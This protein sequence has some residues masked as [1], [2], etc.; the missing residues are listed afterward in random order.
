MEQALSL[1]LYDAAIP[2][3][4]RMLRNLSVMLDKAEAHATAQGLD[5]STL[6]DARLAPDM[7]PLTRQIQSVSDAAKG[8]AAR[9]AGLE[10]PSFPD[11]ETS[12]RSGSPGPSTSSNRSSRSR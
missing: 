11:T 7:F 4:L 12:S 6:L 9:L 10:P 8:G 5:L 3:Y 2:G 1:S